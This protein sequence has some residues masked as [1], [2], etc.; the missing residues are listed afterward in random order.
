M[1]SVYGPYVLEVKK[2]F[3][4]K[5]D[6]CRNAMLLSAYHWIQYY[7]DIIGKAALISSRVSETKD[8]KVPNTKE[9]QDK[10]TEYKSVR[11]MVG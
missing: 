10:N 4:L 1:T 7:N 5:M 6:I 9:H 11:T 3:H 2:Y 8:Q